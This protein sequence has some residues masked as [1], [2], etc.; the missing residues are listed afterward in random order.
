MHGEALLAGVQFEDD[1]LP[2]IPGPIKTQAITAVLHAM[3][4]IVG[5][6]LLRLRNE[7]V[8]SRHCAHGMSRRTCCGLGART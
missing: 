5:L 6:E 3:G 7:P 4:G 8:K 1:D 2:C